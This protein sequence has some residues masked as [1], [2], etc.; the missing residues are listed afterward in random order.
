MA[1]Q[2]LN[3]NI[4]VPNKEKISTTLETEFGKDVV[5]KYKCI[6]WIGI[7]RSRIQILNCLNIID[8]TY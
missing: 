6:M 8:E 4:I 1:T 2:I 3:V 5:H 7:Y